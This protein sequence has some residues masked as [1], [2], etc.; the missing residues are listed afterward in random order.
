MLW[1]AILQV[2]ERSIKRLKEMDKGA[3][4]RKGVAL[5]TNEGQ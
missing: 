1:V 5:V 4:P 3:T 2:F